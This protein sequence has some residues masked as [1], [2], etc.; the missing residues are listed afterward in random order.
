[1]LKTYR[2]HDEAREH[3]EDVKGPAEEQHREDR[4]SGVSVVLHLQ[5]SAAAARPTHLEQIHRINLSNPNHRTRRQDSNDDPDL[6]VPTGEPCLG[7]PAS[8]STEQIQPED[9]FFGVDP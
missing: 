9:D 3:D 1:M 5:E 4:S 6:E 2:L 8:D 7:L